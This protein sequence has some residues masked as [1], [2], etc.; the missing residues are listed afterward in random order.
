M[1]RTIAGLVE[2]AAEDLLERFGAA[3]ERGRVAGEIAAR[4]VDPIQAADALL[5]LYLGLYVLV[6]SGVAR[7]SALAVMA[8]QAQTL[9]PSSS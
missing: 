4:A 2:A 6:H 9:L 1:G 5:G 8:R 7:E 3:I